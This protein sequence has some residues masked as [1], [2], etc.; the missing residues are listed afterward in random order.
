MFF[1]L[2]YSNTALKTSIIAIFSLI[3]VS[4][5]VSLYLLNLCLNKT[6]LGEGLNIYSLYS[7]NMM[8]SITH[9]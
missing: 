6:S 2:F 4:Y 9:Y 8:N 5:I 1:F 3:I 7:S